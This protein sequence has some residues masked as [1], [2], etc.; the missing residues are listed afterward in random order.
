MLYKY[1]EII[2]HNQVFKD[3]TIKMHISSIMKLF[4]LAFATLSF[5]APTPITTPIGA[6]VEYAR[7]AQESPIHLVELSNKRD[8]PIDLIQLP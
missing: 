5:A 4:L 3:P 1:L 8:G 7:A 6:A 2:L